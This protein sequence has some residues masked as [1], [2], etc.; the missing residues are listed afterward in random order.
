MR[1]V[2]RRAHA[3]AKAVK[4][5]IGKMKQEVFSKLDFTAAVTSKCLSVAMAGQAPCPRLIR[6]EEDKSQ[7]P[8]RTPQAPTGSR[9]SHFRRAKM[10]PFLRKL[11]KSKTKRYRVRFLCAYDTSAADCGP[12]GQG[13]IVESKKWQQW[14]RKCLPLVQV[15]LK[16]E[17]YVDLEELDVSRTVLVAFYV[18]AAVAQVVRR[19]Q[20]C[21]PYQK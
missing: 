17:G 10:D 6:V 18:G 14:L 11:G 8:T 16:E 9:F 15:R 4:T 19:C 2:E 12:D 20:A 21:R 5:E 1:S 3:N 13:Y 7:A